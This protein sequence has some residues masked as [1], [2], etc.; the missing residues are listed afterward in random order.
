VLGIIN[1]LND[2]AAGHDEIRAKLFKKVALTISEPLN[3]LSEDWKGYTFIQG[4]GS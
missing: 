2:N 1:N 3:H 4:R